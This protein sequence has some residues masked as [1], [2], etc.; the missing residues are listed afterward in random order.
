MRKAK[1]FP[2]IVVAMRVEIN[3]KKSC[4]HQNRNRPSQAK[5]LRKMLG[6]AMTLGLFP[7][8]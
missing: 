3:L 5:N 7:K 2:E 4:D 6:S 8:I 1:I